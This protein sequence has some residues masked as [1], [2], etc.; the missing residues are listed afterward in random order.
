MY[1][2]TVSVSLYF[3]T[4]FVVVGFFFPSSPDTILRENYWNSGWAYIII[5]I[6]PCRHRSR[7]KNDNNI[8]EGKKKRKEKY[9]RAA[10]LPPPWTSAHVCVPYKRIRTE[11]QQPTN[12]CIHLYC[13]CQFFFSLFLPSRS[14]MKRRRRQIL[15]RCLPCRLLCPRE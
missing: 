10:R 1:V 4:R 12:K 7:I 5:I 15:R 3:R 6:V 14:L 13:F 9:T 2:Y 8:W 11:K